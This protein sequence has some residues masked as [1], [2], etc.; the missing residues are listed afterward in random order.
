MYGK[1]GSDIICASISVLI[2]N[3]INAII[4]LNGEE[5]EYA[6]DEAEGVIIFRVPHMKKESTGTLFEALYMGLDGIRSEYGKKYLELR[7]KEVRK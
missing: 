7:K 3:T 4:N 2:I 1:K 6:E 5:H